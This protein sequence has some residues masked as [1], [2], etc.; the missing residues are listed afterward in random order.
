MRN[1]PFLAEEEDVKKCVSPP[2]VPAHALIAAVAAASSLTPAP[3]CVCVCVC[4]AFAPFGTVLEVH[5]PRDDANRP[6]G[7][8]Y[9][10]FAIPAH[11]VRALADL[12]GSVFQGRL[13][14]V[15]VR[16]SEPA[17]PSV[18]V[19]VRCVLVFAHGDDDTSP[20]VCAFH[21]LCSR[22][23]P[24]AWPRRTRGRRQGRTRK[25][26]CVSSAPIAQCAQLTPH[27]CVAP[28]FPPGARAQEAGGRQ[29]QLEPLLRESGHRGG[30]SGGEARRGKGTLGSPVTA[31]GGERV[32]V[33]DSPVSLVS[34]AQGELL[35]RD[36]SGSAMAV[37]LALAETQVIADT[38]KVGRSGP[39]LSWPAGTT[40]T[41][42]RSPHTDA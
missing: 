36:E 41:R 42:T 23:A 28:P 9:V 16:C 40:L 7:F 34:V 29:H 25:R 15:L 30:G 20:P 32:G 26:M 10:Q 2:L 4:S 14:H 38:R 33:A 19:C 35:N 13:L 5:L 6:K 18:C 8:A 3:V 37:Q 31:R 17:G 27:V 11:A 12:D 39:L 21:P 24:P 22:R 1:L